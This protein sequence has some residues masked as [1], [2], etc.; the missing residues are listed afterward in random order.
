MKSDKPITGKKEKKDFRNFLKSENKRRAKGVKQGEEL[1]GVNNMDGIQKEQ[2]VKNKPSLLQKFS[3]EPSADKKARK[4][5]KKEWQRENKLVFEAM[6][7]D[8][9]ILSRLNDTKTKIVL[10]VLVPIIFM[11]AYG[12]V[13]YGKSSSAI[14]SS[15]ETNMDQTVG[16]V[17][18][19]LSLGFDSVKDKSVELLLSKSVSNYFIRLNKE[20]TIEDYN[21]LKTV[22]QEVM[23]INQTNPFVSNVYIFTS[24]GKPIVTNGNAPNDL[25]DQFTA[26]EQGQ[27]LSEKKISNRWIGDHSSLDEI[28][29][30]DGSKYTMSIVTRMTTPDGYIILDVDKKAVLSSLQNICTVPGSVAALIAPDGKETNTTESGDV[31]FTKADFYKEAL[32]S[33]KNNGSDYVS[34]DGGSYLFVYK[35]VGDTGSLVCALIP[36]GEILK[37]V[38]PLKILNIVFIL[39]AS[40]L[41]IIIGCV[42]A[43]GIGRAIRRLMVSI[44]KAAKGDLTVEFDTSKKDEFGILAKSLHDMTS[45][46]KQLIG[47]VY[48]VGAK[49]TQSSSELSQTSDQILTAT[50]GISLTIDEIEGGVVQQA[51]DTE[52]CLGQ[53]ARLS[54]QIGQVY[55]NTYEIEKKATDT[56]GVIGEGIVTIDEL[57]KKAK[58]T[59]EV[60][61]TVIR[62]IEE[63]EV[64]SRSINSFV[65]I[66]NE[67]AAQTNLLS[68]NA[69]IE[70]ARAGEAGRGFAV[71]ADEIRKLADQSVEAVRQI[72]DIVKD[73]QNKTQGTVE[74]AKKAGE[75]VDSQTEALKK[76]VSTFEKINSYVGG[77]VSNLDNI[78]IGVKGIE[79]AKEDTLDAVRSISA[80]S[81][82]TAAASE[83]VSAT[84]NAQIGAV[85][86]LSR[87]ATEL[88]EDA[89]KLEKAIKLFKIQ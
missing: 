35:A 11:T 15:Y 45:N 12:W 55:S 32:K 26:S 18:D 33:G 52:K 85:E 24:T 80:V 47:E 7:S 78:S 25:Y 20:D 5:L 31:L 62:S 41:A 9:G 53:M 51:D 23:I 40:I 38:Q 3:K 42:I 34:Y 28:L 37:K 70:A 89:K 65:D 56:K 17:G 72:Q 69:S 29:S 6:V 77:L 21:N 50:K 64:K 81:Q 19:Y 57:G 1:N 16:A 14:T 59:S 48:Q 66:I 30:R 74:S 79:A 54:D 58:D 10:T 83:E 71:V 2:K 67:I 4:A 73:I 84:A 87:S 68:L 8:K 88:E 86:N 75:I 36:K 43:M 60:T 46:M 44:S 39:V 27:S 61:Q 49:V 82:E 22:Q 76:T 63:L 13:S